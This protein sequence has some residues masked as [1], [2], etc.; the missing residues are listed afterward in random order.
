MN[1]ARL[2]LSRDQLLIVAHNNIIRG[3]VT[4]ANLMELPWSSICQDDVTSPFC[5]QID[6]VQGAFV[7]SCS[8]LQ[9]S[10]AQRRIQHHPWLDLIPFIAFRD[11]VLAAIEKLWAKQP[12]R[13]TELCEDLTGAGELALRTGRPGMMVWDDPWD[14]C[15]WEVSEEFAQKWPQMLVGCHDLVTASNCWRRSRGEP[16]LQR[17]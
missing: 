17:G 9:P 14:A 12:N 13:E 4:I 2:I 16:T 5:S 7:S 8:A 15:S 1:A 10:R 3:L 6:A 11:N